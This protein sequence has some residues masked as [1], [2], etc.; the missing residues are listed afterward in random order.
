M[1][2]AMRP[3]ADSPIDWSAARTFG[4]RIDGA[5]YIVRTG[6]YAVIFHDDGRVAVIQTAGGYYLPGGG[7]EA[8]ETVEE[9]LRREVAEEC[10]CD[11]VIRRRLG[12]AVQLV[13]AEGEGYFE[14][15]CV[16]FEASLGAMNAAPLDPSDKLVWL[17]A[18]VA[19]AEL[20]PQ[21][22][23]WAIGLAITLRS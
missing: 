16:F 5:S 13:F 14:K 3:G 22:Q 21:S 19:A 17:N 4:R 7:A 10:G 23:A 11:V 15:R 2:Y 20:R 6:V 1:L 18:E 8:G 12:E 9:T